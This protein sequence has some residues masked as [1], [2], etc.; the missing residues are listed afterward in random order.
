[1]KNEHT[2]SL[3]KNL[4]LGRRSC[5]GKNRVLLKKEKQSSNLQELSIKTVSSFSITRTLPSA[6]YCLRIDDCTL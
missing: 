2:L 4:F 1:V 5:P 3:S 6:I